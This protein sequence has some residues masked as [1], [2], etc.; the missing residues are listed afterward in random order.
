[1]L[2]QF[3]VIVGPTAGGKSALVIALAHA[4]EPEG[5]I[6]SADSMQI[7]QGIDIGT[8]KPSAEERRRVP[9]HLIDLIEPTDSFSVDQ[10]L[11]L[12]NATIDSTRS[13]RS[14]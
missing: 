10:W 5:E 1:M 12:A 8:A 2:Q 11:K 4:L 7:Y 6:V 9:H 3:P 14:G 13:F